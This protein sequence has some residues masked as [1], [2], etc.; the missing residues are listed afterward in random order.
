MRDKQATLKTV[1]QEWGHLNEVR[2]DK[3]NGKQLTPGLET[4]HSCPEK[5]WYAFLTDRTMG[6]ICLKP[7]KKTERG[8]Q[9]DHALP[10]WA[11]IL[12][13]TSEAWK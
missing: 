12:A 3:D 2:G 1:M 10:P 13:M 4:D 8:L 11:Q 7:S 9:P 6:G 5:G